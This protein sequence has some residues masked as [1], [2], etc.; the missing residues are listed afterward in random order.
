MFRWG[1]DFIDSCIE[2]LSSHPI[3][4]IVLA[5]IA[6]L[7]IYFIFVKFFKMVLILGLILLAL[8]G[9]FYYQSPDEFTDNVKK[10]LKGVKEKSD[11]MVEKVKEVLEESKDLT[12]GIGKVVERGKK[13]ILG[14]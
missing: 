12:E 5:A 10:T 7:M 8:G 13:A 6:L 11:K 14:K 4:I 2:Y 1:R 3:A 9:Y